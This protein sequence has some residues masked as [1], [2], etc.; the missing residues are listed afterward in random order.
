LQQQLTALRRSTGKPGAAGLFSLGF[1]NAEE[2]SARN[3]ANTA[4]ELAVSFRAEGTVR[5]FEVLVALF[6]G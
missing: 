2:V 5:R 6:G 1:P 4:R 3:I